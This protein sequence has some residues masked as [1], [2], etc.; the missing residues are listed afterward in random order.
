MPPRLGTASRRLALEA[1]RGE[2]ELQAASASVCFLAV[3]RDTGD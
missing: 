3:Q 1:A 2:R